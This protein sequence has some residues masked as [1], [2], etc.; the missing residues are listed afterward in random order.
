MEIKI[1]SRLEFVDVILLISE[2]VA[3]RIGFDENESF[4]IKLAVEEALANAI[5]H[6]NKLDPDKKVI[7]CFAFDDNHIEVSVTDEG[8]CFNLQDTVDPREAD[9]LFKGNGRGL[10]LI[11][12]LMDEV[13]FRCHAPKGMEVDMRKNRR[14]KP[15]NR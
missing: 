14:K 2:K 8:T 5:K 13:N 4:D 10:F 9:H 7:T 12:T 3:E 15:C 1:D 11:K 6:G